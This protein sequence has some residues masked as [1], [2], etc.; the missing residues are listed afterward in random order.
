MTAS[1]VV[2]IARAL[3]A[4]RIA[5]GLAIALA[6]ARAGAVL[7]GA[8]ARA[9]GGRLFVAAFGARDALLGLGTLRALLRGE[10]AR[11]WMATCAAADAFDAGVCVAHPGGLAP[12]LRVRSSA[13]SAIPAAAG[14]CL[15]Y[16]LD[17]G[18]GGCRLHPAP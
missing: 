9:P 13:V 8:D 17:G 16:R 12:P 4:V 15:A 1:S 11:W 14:A 6:P 3:A 10:D 5:S 2:R 18:R 7:V